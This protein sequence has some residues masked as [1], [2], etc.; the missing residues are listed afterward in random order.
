MKGTGK[1]LSAT[2]LLVRAYWQKN[3]AFNLILLCT[4]AMVTLSSFCVFSLVQGKL[5]ADV[6]SYIYDAGMTADAYVENGTEDISDEI[7]NLSF[8]SRVGYE[9]RSGKLFQE[10]NP[11]CECVIYEEETF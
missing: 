11:F 3:K 9:K 1:H 7:E 2:R 5:N 6:K 10:G 4:V 8:A